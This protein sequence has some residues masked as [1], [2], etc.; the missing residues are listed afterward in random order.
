MEQGWQ[1]LRQF[2]LLCFRG[3]NGEG[4]YVS[5]SLYRQGAYTI[6]FDMNIALLWG[7]TLAVGN[8]E[9]M[10]NPAMNNYVTGDG[11]RFW[12]VGLEI[13]VIGRPVPGCRP[14]GMDR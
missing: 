10:G 4:Q 13:F 12:I 7:M 6:G 9:S 1:L 3:E 11:K 14:S 2:P 8:R 5:T